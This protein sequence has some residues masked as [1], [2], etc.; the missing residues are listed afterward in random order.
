MS[1][2]IKIKAVIMRINLHFSKHKFY[3]QMLLLGEKGKYK[4]TSLYISAT[5]IQ[6]RRTDCAPSTQWRIV[7]LLNTPEEYIDFILDQVYPDFNLEV[8]QLQQELI[9]T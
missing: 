6:I 8:F 1:K 5:K 7:D 4:V 3:P 9:G 2:E